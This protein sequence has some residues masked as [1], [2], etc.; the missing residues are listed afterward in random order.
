MELPPL[1]KKSQMWWGTLV[2]LA[3]GEWTQEIPEAQGSARRAL[4]GNSREKEETLS[5][6]TNNKTK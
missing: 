6:Q 5:Q 3:R 2:G 1:K 4:L